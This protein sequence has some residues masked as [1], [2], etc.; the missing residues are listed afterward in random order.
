PAHVARPLPIH[1]EAV[2]A[3]AAG[4]ALSFARGVEMDSVAIGAQQH[5]LQSIE[6]CRLPGTV[7]PEESR[8]PTDIKILPCVEEILDQTNRLKLLHRRPPLRRLRSRR[9]RP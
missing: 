3:E 9:R 8:V 2:V 7:G 5:D 4:P 1:A 6:Q